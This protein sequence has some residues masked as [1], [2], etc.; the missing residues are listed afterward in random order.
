MRFSSLIRIGLLILFS[1]SPFLAILTS[2]ISSKG[3]PFAEYIGGV[4][5]IVV[6][7]LVFMTC[8]AIYKA[9]VIK[10]KSMT[11]FF[12]ISFFL[13]YFSL[14]FI[15]Y[16]DLLLILDGVRYQL[17]YVAL[18][19]TLVV[20]NSFTL[21]SFDIL[22]LVCKIATIHLLLALLIAIMEFFDP[23]VIEIIYGVS[24][25]NMNNVELAVGTRLISIL[26][27]PINLGAFVVFGQIC[28]FYIAES[29]NNN[30]TWLVFWSVSAVSLFVIL[31]TYS[32]LALI[33]F[34][35][36]Y[37][38][39]VFRG[40]AK[41]RFII[42][43]LLITSL[44]V[45]LASS[46]TSY[47][48]FSGIIER[49]SNLGTSKE[50]TDN[51]RVNNWNSAYIKLINGDPVSMLWGLGSGAS[52]PSF[53]SGGVIVEN[54]FISILVDFGFIG[55]G[56]YAII[57]A[58]FIFNAINLRH[59]KT[60]ESFLIITFIIFFIVMSMGND[61]NRNFP[62]VFY[63]WLFFYFSFSERNGVYKEKVC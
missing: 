60:E 35:I 40:V 29:K 42:P 8:V 53:N 33:A 25:E 37:A 26:S 36:V 10:R 54:S 1:I 18:G 30:F 2:Y 22:P 63:F 39:F 14:H 44:S 32:R 34:S 38:M 21:K 49:L 46:I 23:S 3:V 27:N 11:M 58:I 6:L 12:L 13:V 9:N 31:F 41:R 15:G 20:Y 45:F 24:K 51:T 62:F 48:D 43:V 55:A 47:D 61:F 4:K 7:F 19:C 16:V 28:F 50:Y 56:M 52:N 59:H 5:D 57:I 17:I